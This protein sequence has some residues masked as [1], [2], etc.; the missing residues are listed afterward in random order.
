MVENKTNQLILWKIFCKIIFVGLNTLYVSDGL[1][2]NKNRYI[3]KHF[4]Y[5]C[6]NHKKQQI[7]SIKKV[8]WLT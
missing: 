5:N 3:W 4:N 8:H 6:F 1:L 7:Y 2:Y